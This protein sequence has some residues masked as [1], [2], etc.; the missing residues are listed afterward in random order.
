MAEIVMIPLSAFLAKALSTR[1]LFVL[2]A[3]LF[4]IASLLCGLAWDLRSMVL[5]RAMQGF[6]GGAMIPL[7]FA[8]GFS[9]FDGPKAAMA[10][11]VLGVIS[12]LAPTLGPTIGGWVTDTLGWRWL[13]FMNIAPGVL[14]TLA[15]VGLGRF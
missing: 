6:V 9:F 1:W 12:T 13:F 3:A 2:S 11:A 4:T 10:T 7:V 14:V 15:L 8:T 5:F